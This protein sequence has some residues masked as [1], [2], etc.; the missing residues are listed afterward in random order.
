MTFDGRDET[1]AVIAIT[2]AKSPQVSAALRTLERKEDGI[3]Q[4]QK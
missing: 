2:K 3:R 1:V 4:I